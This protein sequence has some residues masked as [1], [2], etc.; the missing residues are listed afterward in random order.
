M[1]NY[2][3][4]S[5]LDV[6]D[7]AH[8]TDRDDAFG[9]PG[10]APKSARNGPK[11][12][13]SQTMRSDRMDG[14]AGSG[15]GANKG[16][17]PKPRISPAARKQSSGVGHVHGGS[18]SKG[19]SPAKSQWGSARPQGKGTGISIGTGQS[20]ENDAIKSFKRDADR[21]AKGGIH[22]AYSPA[23]AKGPEQWNQSNFDPKKKGAG[24]VSN[25]Y[26]D[27]EGSPADRTEPEPF[28]RRGGKISAT[29]DDPTGSVKS[30]E[31]LSRPVANKSVSSGVGHMYSPGR[32]SSQGGASVPP[33]S[34][35]PPAPL[36]RKSSRLY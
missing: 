22:A 10:G 12:P 17:G 9:S 33:P 23:D 24:K 31:P 5:G 20:P 27:S 4:H 36:R 15:R 28:K 6:P 13:P 25:L 11:K 29:Q 35:G 2:S 32:G 3:P 16:P 18:M 26:T 30:R 34:F 7:Y 8:S 19:G 21:G 14:N 1:A